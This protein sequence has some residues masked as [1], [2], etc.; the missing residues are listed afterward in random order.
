MSARISV[1]TSGEVH[2]DQ[3]EGFADVGVMIDVLG[4]GCECE[5]LQ[6]AR[7]IFGVDGCDVVVVVECVFD[8]G[9]RAR[10]VRCAIGV[11]VGW[12]VVVVDC[13]FVRGEYRCE[14]II[15]VFDEF[16]FL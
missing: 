8:D 5:D 12:V 11:G 1:S 4:L 10:G 6:I 7:M 3:L 15:V 2:I 13:E 9:E 16:C 14:G